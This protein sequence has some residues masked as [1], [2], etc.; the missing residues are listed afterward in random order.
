[1]RACDEENIAL[2][3]LTSLA[4]LYIL[5]AKA[6]A[7]IVAIIGD[8]R[9]HCCDVALDGFRYI[10]CRCSNKHEWRAFSKQYQGF[11]SK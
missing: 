8:Y 4:F 10:S 7:A 3:A 9:Y 5:S 11:L 2:A 1:M 6:A